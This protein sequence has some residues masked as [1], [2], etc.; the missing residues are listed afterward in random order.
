MSMK[1]LAVIGA[2]SLCLSLAACDSIGNAIDSTS[3]K[4][5]LCHAGDDKE[6]SNGAV[7]PIEGTG[8]L[9]RCIVTNGFGK[10]EIVP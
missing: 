3:G 5:N 4:D 8:K 6:Y 9:Q 7:I 2:T 10:W 1:L